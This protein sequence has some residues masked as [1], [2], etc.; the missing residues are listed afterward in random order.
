M[1][2]KDFKKGNL[3]R[4]E[5][6]GFIDLLMQYSEYEDFQRESQLLYC[7]WLDRTVRWSDVE[8]NKETLDETENTINYFKGHLD[9]V[10]QDISYYQ[11]KE[12]D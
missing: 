12:I 3:S 8:M 6:E 9:R 5:V 2:L 4:R 10:F 7:L 11:L 1:N